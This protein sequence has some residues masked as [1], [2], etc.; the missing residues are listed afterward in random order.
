MNQAIEYYLYKFIKVPRRIVYLFTCSINSDCK[1][2]P[3]N[4][5][6]PKFTS[7]SLS[8]PCYMLQR[9]LSPVLMQLRMAIDAIYCRLIDS[10]DHA[11]LTPSSSPEKFLI[12]DRSVV[13]HSCQLDV[14]VCAL[15]SLEGSAETPRP[16]FA[17]L[18]D[19][20]AVV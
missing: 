11:E 8:A 2:L 6:L 10:C 9:N 1:L 7:V 17:V 14:V 4:A 20:N 13:N 16:C 5:S 12:S 3:R 19:G 18:V 15:A